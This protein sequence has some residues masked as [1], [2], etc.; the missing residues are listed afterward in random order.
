MNKAAPPPPSLWR[1]PRR[2]FSVTFGV[3]PDMA[4]MR[5][6]LCLMLFISALGFPQGSDSSNEPEETIQKTSP[7]RKLDKEDVQC[8]NYLWVATK[9]GT[10]FLYYFFGSTE[11]GKGKV[12]FYQ[13]RLY[14][15]VVNAGKEPPTVQ[16]FKDAQGNVTEIRIQM[17]GQELEASSA[18]LPER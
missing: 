10:K 11:W 4:S 9:T 5:P 16:R 3:E 7:D 12:G 2:N 18:C 15:A 1:V 6:L 17:T 13:Q 14:R 8:G